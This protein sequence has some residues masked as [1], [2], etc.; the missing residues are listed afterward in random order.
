LERRGRV[1]ERNR[2]D[3]IEIGFLSGKRTYKQQK[4]QQ[5]SYGQLLLLNVLFTVS[6][7]C[8]NSQPESRAQ[9][10][11]ALP[12]VQEQILVQRKN[13]FFSWMAEF[14]APEKQPRA[15]MRKTFVE[16]MSNVSHSRDS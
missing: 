10:A 9:R 5:M 8:T 13:V 12:L 14:L 16:C 3:V 7:C 2:G 15:S 1:G 6:G 11:F 4:D